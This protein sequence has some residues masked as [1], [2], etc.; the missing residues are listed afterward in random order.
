MNVDFDETGPTLNESTLARFEKHLG[1][2]LPHDY[3]E[4]LLKSNG[5]Q[6]TDD[7][8]FAFTEDGK[9]SGSVVSE[10]YSL[11]EE[12][13]RITLQKGIDTFVKRNRMP[14]W[15]LPVAD[16]AFGNQICLS[17]AKENFGSVFF[18]D[19]EREPDVS[20]ECGSMLNV[21]LIARS[22]SEFLNLLEPTN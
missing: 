4:F 8:S 16:D 14:A 5:G 15:F 10:F 17:L 2:Q 6:P 18:W 21:S 19:H 13:E 12:S 7:L 3:R 11:A 22:F 9:P 1:N 20:D